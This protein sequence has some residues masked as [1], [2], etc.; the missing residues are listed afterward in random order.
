MDEPENATETYIERSQALLEEF[1]Q[2]GEENTKAKLI[3]PLLELLGWDVYSAEVELEYPM[4]IGR[5]NTRADYAL[6]LDGVPVVFIE[7]KGFDST[8]STSD[9]TQLTSYMRQKGVDWGLLTNGATFEVLKRR[10]NSARPEE[11]SLDHFTLDELA[12]H[13][14]VLR[15]LSKELVKTGEADTIAQRIE[16]RQR[17]VRT[18]K[19]NKEDIA[20]GVTNVVTDEVGDTLAQEIETES[21]AFIDALVTSL[22]TDQETEVQVPDQEPE[23]AP[24]ESSAGEHIITFWEEGDLVHSF[25]DTNQSDV[26]AAAIDVLIRDYELIDR[27]DSFPYVPGETTAVLNSEPVH[28]TGEEM[29]LSRELSSGYY[30][31]TGLGKESKQRYVTRFANL[32]GLTA[33]FEGQW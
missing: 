30:L 6:L 27:F 5:G 33:E 16:A 7:A 14:S 12:D 10:Q 23:T 9:R 32:C 25:S 17:A 11:V 31:F 21:K 29:V 19:G 2:M 3:Q 4:Q 13:W 28:P 15:L 22:G 1:P 8:L 18:L 20:E 24:E 26:M